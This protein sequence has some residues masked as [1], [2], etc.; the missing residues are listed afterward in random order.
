MNKKKMIGAASY[1]RNKRKLS[2]TEMKVKAW[3]SG[4]WGLLSEVA[5]D[6]DVS[7]QYVQRIAY[8]RSDG[9]SAGLRIAKALL[10]KG[11]PGRT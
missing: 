11:W 2:A 8:G 10:V 4:N 6:C 3:I 9:P 7:P 1:K 5:K